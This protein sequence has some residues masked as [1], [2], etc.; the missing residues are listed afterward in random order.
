MHKPPFAPPDL[1]EQV[2]IVTGASRG[3]G[4]VIALALAAAGA[5]VVIAA[6]SEQSRERLPGNIHQTA[7]EVR[8]LG[9]RALAVK[10]NVRNAEEVEAM[11]HATLDEFGRIDILLNNAGAMFWRPVLQTPVKRFDL[12]MEVNVRAA[13]LATHEVLPHMLQQGSGC[14]V[15]MSPPLALDMM[16]GKTPYC[17]SKFGMSLLAMG[18]AQEVGEAAVRSCALWP[19]TAIESQ[20]TINHGLGEPKD[21]RKADILADATLA[22]LKAPLQ[23]VQGRCLI[24][25][26]ALALVGVD[27]FAAYNCVEGAEPI[28]IVGDGG[29]QAK[30]WQT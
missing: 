28:R 13:Y 25:E 14:I 6:K 16:A 12:M 22:L 9:R 19:S 1:H 4:K 26:Q 30:L 29:V 23:Q 7:E 2:A 18:L 27:D 20:A 17:I 15:Q 3:I 11:V 5:D 24:D 21:W 8:A 10:T